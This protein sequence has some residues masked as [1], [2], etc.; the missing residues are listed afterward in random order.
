MW[1]LIRWTSLGSAVLGR[2]L[3]ARRLVE[4]AFSARPVSVLTFGPE[5]A[6]LAALAG[7]P[8]Y[9]EQELLLDATFAVDEHGRSAAFEVAVAVARQN[10]KTGFLKQAALGWLFV[11][12]QR[13]VVWSAHEMSTAA[14]AHRDLTDLIESTPVLSKRLLKVITANGKE[15]VELRSGQRVKFKARTHGGGRGLTGDR[16]VLDEAMFLQASHLGALLPTLTAVPDP[17]VVMAGSA[18]MATSEVWRAVR[19]RGRKRLSPRLAWLEWCAPLV[20]CPDGCMHLPGAGG[21]A[22]DREEL[23][24]QANPLLA[25]RPQLLVTMRAER[26]ALPPAEFARERLGWWDEAPSADCKVDGAA[27]AACGVDLPERPDG[28]PVFFVDCSPGL[29]SSAVAAAVVIDG[30]PYVE[31]ADY[32]PGADWLVGRCAELRGRYPGARFGWLAAGAAS[33]LRADVEAAGVVVEDL[34]GQDYGRA[35]TLLE[36]AVPGRRVRHSGDALFAQALAG[37]VSK[38]VG[39]DLWCWSRRKSTSADLSPLVAA[40]G[41]LWLAVNV[42]AADVWGFFS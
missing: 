35:C 12:D 10:L 41:A 17:Q 9:P 31:L 15:A 27:W 24:G 21:C 34:S 5:V 30:A 16:V 3:L 32:R 28:V 2:S 23:Y 26:Q 18:G 1:L 8:P 42:P 4:P 39:D 36:Q 7:F 29:R 20:D 40:T 6:E 13:L 38:P 11:T 14:E 33:S 19:D 37:A 25:E 22:L